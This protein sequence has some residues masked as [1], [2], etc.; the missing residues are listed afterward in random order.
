MAL[1]TLSSIGTALPQQTNKATFFF[2]SSFWN[3]L[4]AGVFGFL[5]NLPIVN[6][7]EHGTYLTVNHGHTALFGV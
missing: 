7:F 6:Y 5:I 1:S 3:F 4:G 2:A